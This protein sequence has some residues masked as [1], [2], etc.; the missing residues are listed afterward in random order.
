MTKKILS[1]A[2]LTVLLSGCGYSKTE[3]HDTCQKIDSFAKEALNNPSVSN[4][5][6][7][8]VKKN[9]EISDCIVITEKGIDWVF[10]R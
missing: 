7:T 10:N 2:L 1:I 9:G 5:N 8:L 3:I 6:S 4:Y